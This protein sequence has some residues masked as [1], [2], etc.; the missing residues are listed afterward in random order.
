MRRTDERYLARLQTRY[1]KASKRERNEILDDF[2]K[3]AGCSRKEDQAGFCEGEIP[4][5][6]QSQETLL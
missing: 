6:Q 1:S 3:T 4:R 5:G 2:V